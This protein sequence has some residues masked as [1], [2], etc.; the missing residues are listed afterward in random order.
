MAAPGF[1]I[2]PLE[3]LILV[4]CPLMLLVLGVLVVV[5]LSRGRGDSQSNG[6]G[7]GVAVAIVVGLL[8]LCLCGG[9]LLGGLFF[10]RSAPMAQP[11]PP[12]KVQE[13]PV[14]MKQVPEPA[15]PATTEEPSEEPVEAEPPV[16]DD[17]DGT[18]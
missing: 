3:L 5:V 16:S 10:V 17:S 11:M 2:G 8:L 13:M 7:A 6:S 4:A 14:E 12:V 1:G 9:G 18:N 15:D